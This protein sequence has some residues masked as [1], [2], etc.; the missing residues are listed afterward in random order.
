MAR[1]TSGTNFAISS[2]Q[3]SL[4]WDNQRVQWAR[5]IIRLIA[6]VIIIAAGSIFVGILAGF[7]TWTETFPIFVLLLLILP[8]WWGSRRYGWKWVSYFPS[9]LCFFLAVYVT[10]QSGFITIFVLVY[11]LAVLLAGILLNNRLGYLVTAASMLC[12][13]WLTLAGIFNFSFA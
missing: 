2:S 6:I 13:I 12:G 9:A 10:S 4:D 8:V 3:N 7:F 1:T 5:D 11:A